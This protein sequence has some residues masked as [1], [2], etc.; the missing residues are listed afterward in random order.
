MSTMDAGVEPISTTASPV[1]HRRRQAHAPALRE[2]RAIPIV[3]VN[4]NDPIGAGF[5]ASVARPGGNLT[6]LLHYE[7]GISGKFVAA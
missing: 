4:V 5:V 6:G 7:E 3:F 2:T 1:T